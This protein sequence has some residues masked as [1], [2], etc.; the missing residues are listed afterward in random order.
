MIDCDKCFIKLC[1]HIIDSCEY[2]VRVSLRDII[3]TFQLTTSQ[4]KKCIKK[5]K[6]DKYFTFELYEDLS[7]NGG[8]YLECRLSGDFYG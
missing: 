3:Y 7:G 1:R 2:T 6:D 5:Y 8:S 4:L